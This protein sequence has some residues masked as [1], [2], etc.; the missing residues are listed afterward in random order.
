M[1]SNDGGRAAL[2]IDAG[3]VDA[4][5]D[6]IESTTVDWDHPFAADATP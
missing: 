2:F 4:K 3:H 6:P 5:F 1:M